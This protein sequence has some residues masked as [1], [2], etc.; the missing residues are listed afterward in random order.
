MPSSLLVD[1]DGSFRLVSGTGRSRWI[2][3]ESGPGGWARV[4]ERTPDGLVET[5]RSAASSCL[6][7][8][9]TRLRVDDDR[10]TRETTTQYARGTVRTDVEDVGEK[11]VDRA[12]T[13]TYRDGS[14]AEATFDADGGRL[15]RCV[16]RA[17]NEAAFTTAAQAGPAGLQQV[18]DRVT[19][20]AW[21]HEG[22]IIGST[23]LRPGSSSTVVQTP[24][25]GGTL[26][27][28]VTRGLDG[29][30]T[31][32]G[33]TGHGPFSASGRVVYGSDGT[34]TKSAGSSVQT[35]T[36]QT[37]VTGDTGS[38]SGGHVITGHTDGG[39]VDGGGF[40]TVSTASTD[41]QVTQRSSFS[42]DGQGN[43]SETTVTYGADGGFTIETT[44]TDSGGATTT[45]KQ[46]FDHEGHEVGGGEPA[47]GEEHPSGGRENPGDGDGDHPHGGEEG[48][49]P[50]G[51]GTDDRPSGR[52]SGAADAALTA[53]LGAGGGSTGGTGARGEGAGNPVAT[54]LTAADDEGFGAD[55]GREGTPIDLRPYL[56]GHPGGDDG[57]M[58]PAALVHAA[59][60]LLGATATQ[61]LV[62]LTQQVGVW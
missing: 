44:S 45:T 53:L 6:A 11:G 54:V 2:A 29:T 34:V 13:W 4:V 61:S 40:W 9:L 38:I 16:D 62:A 8:M 32:T 10:L 60:A 27:S 55:T 39:T 59:T 43:T 50:S 28:T 18:T 58:N 15:L 37:V 1:P 20:T 22:I 5:T 33:A 56:V 31:I 19:D 26:V 47:G 48:S 14:R 51:D 57:E 7:S 49:Q 35:G 21:T 24:P 46:E 17:G 23:T 30:I 3:V 52:R 36:G 12:V 25:G 41:G 42:A